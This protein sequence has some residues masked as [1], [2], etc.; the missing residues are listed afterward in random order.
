MISGTWSKEINQIEKDWPGSK[1]LA[2]LIKE[3]AERYAIAHRDPDRVCIEIILTLEC[4]FLN[5]CQ[6]LDM[7]II[8]QYQIGDGEAD[9]MIRAR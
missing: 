7:T 4:T 3:G 2:L 5:P 8:V 9:C 6:V 1:A